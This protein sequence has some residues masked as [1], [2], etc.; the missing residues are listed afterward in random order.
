MFYYLFQRGIQKKS[1]N[2]IQITLNEWI[3][4]FIYFHEFNS[5]GIKKW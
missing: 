3:N 1:L 4:F 5:T 2:V